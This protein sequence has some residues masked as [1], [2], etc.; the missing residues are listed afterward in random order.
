MRFWGRTRA[1]SG[2][3]WGA[4]HLCLTD[5]LRAKPGDHVLLTAPTRGG[6]TPAILEVARALILLAV[7]LAALIAVVLRRAD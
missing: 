1:D 2:H 5:E 6:G 4:E 7:A 3:F